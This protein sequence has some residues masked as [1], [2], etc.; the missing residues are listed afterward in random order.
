MKTIDVLRNLRVEVLDGGFSIPPTDQEDEVMY[1]RFI[2]IDEPQKYYNVNVVPHDQASIIDRLIESIFNSQ[3]D[4]NG[5]Y[6]LNNTQFIVR[7]S[8]GEYHKDL[9]DPRVYI[10][11][12]RV[13]IIVNK[14]DNL[15]CSILER[16]LDEFDALLSRRLIDLVY[17]V[18]Q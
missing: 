13:S 4:L 2:A 6:I 7:I 15:D 14:T 10:P 8:Q 18:I 16:D 11:T 1:L 9:N 3:E 12:R 5:D 17:Y